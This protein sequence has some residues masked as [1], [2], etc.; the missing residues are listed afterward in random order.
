M[1]ANQIRRAMRAN[2]QFVV[3][4]YDVACDRRRRRVVKICLRYGAKRVNYSVMELMA[5][6]A[7]IERMKTDVKQVI[8]QKEDTVIFY[9]LDV[10]SY[11][12]VTYMNA[13]A[14]RGCKPRSVMAV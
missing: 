4:A 7:D 9:P 12:A 2:K 14:R 11:A 13:T 1:R 10:N 5:R 3:I 6:K 8:S